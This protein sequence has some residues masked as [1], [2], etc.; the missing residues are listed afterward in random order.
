[1][2]AQSDNIPETFIK[3]NGKTQYNYNLKTVEKVDEMSGETR[4]IFEYEY[5]E[6][7][8][9]I[10]RS[11]LIEAVIR[12]THSLSDELALLHNKQI[13]KDVAEYDTFQVY[14]DTVKEIVD[15]ALLELNEAP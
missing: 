6:I 13:E 9:D 15:A 4:I 11:K 3:S 14:R 1:M 10:T 8:G 12:N 7:I 5:I 2:K